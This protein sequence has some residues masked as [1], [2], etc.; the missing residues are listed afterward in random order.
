M[1]MAMDPATFRA[2]PGPRPTVPIATR[3]WLA[4][5]ALSLGKAEGVPLM[6]SLLRAM[7]ELEALAQRLLGARPPRTRGRPGPHGV[8]ARSLRVEPFPAPLVR[9]LQ[10][11]QRGS[12]A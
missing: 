12:A 3:E 11:A 4:E 8:G 9:V 7:S 6:W 10:I 2:C 1:K 5:A